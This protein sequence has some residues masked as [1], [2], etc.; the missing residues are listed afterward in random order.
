MRHTL[1]IWPANLFPILEG[2]K[3]CEIR[4]NDRDYHVGDTLCLRAF[5]PDK[6]E[7]VN[8][9][10][11]EREVTW[12]NIIPGTKMVALSIKCTEGM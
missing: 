1:K 3:T 2:K 8:D 9:L 4:V 5:D 12:I 10:I 6:Q 7:F 11:F